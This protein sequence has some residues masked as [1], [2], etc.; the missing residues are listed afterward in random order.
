MRDLVSSFCFDWFGSPIRVDSD[1]P[2]LVRNLEGAFGSLAAAPAADDLVYSVV[3]RAPDGPTVSWPGGT[4]TLDRRDPLAHACSFLTAEILSRVGSHFIIH[5]AALARRGRALLI[6]APSTFGKT[7][8]AVALA[9]RGFDLLTDDLIGIERSSSMVIACPKALGLRAG[10]RRML[11]PDLL[12][13]ARRARRMVT[14]AGAWLVDP[15]RLFGRPAGP[16]SP[17]MIVSVRPRGDGASVRRFPIIRIRFIEGREPAT[18]ALENLDGVD[19]AK[20]DPADPTIVAAH[21]SRHD[22]LE[23]FLESHRDDIVFATK[24]ISNNALFEGEPEFS[25]L[26]TLQA[27][28]EM[29]QEMGN[30]GP[31]SRLH[32][33]F[34]GNPAHLVLDLASHLRAAR[35]WGMTP[36]TL[37]ATLDRLESLFDEACSTNGDRAGSVEPPRGGS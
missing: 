9:G 37:P 4:L 6:C 16:A 25:P 3:L 33:E 21:F 14:D 26:G 22:A 1:T 13:R 12:E 10:T 7:T 17:A 35:C 5:G 28:T 2:A 30:R 36:G 31:G 29:A 23:H 19:Q 20:R 11:A 34:E 8:L 24:V 15:I 18:A 27:A 32:A